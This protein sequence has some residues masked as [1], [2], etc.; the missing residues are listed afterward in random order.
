ME[1]F[2]GLENLPISYQKAVIC[3]GNF[4]GVHTGHRQII[5]ICIS[6][7]QKMAAKS[8]LVTFDRHPRIYFSQKS[9][10][11]ATPLLN[12]ND[13]KNNILSCT[14]LDG[15]LYLEMTE[16]LLDLE[17]ERFLKDVIVDKIKVSKVVFGYDFHFGKDRKGN[18][19][20]MQFCG[21]KYHFDV[22]QVGAL[23]KENEIVSSSLIRKYLLAG[24]LEKSK[25]LLGYDYHFS[26]T[27]VYGSGRGTGLGFPTANVDVSNKYKL[28]PATGV[29]FTKVKINNETK[30]GLCNIG[31][32]P[33]FDEQD[34][35]IEIYIYDL[36][37]KNLY[38]RHIE[39]DLL[40]RLRDEIRYETIEKLIDQMKLDK[41]MGENLMKQYN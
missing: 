7:A 19:D 2:H 12:T 14:A 17:A 28:I 36:D 29:Y 35:I 10:C 27:V 8:L 39:V 34:L 32:R 21:E 1:I 3:L 41:A 20:L 16:E 30:F 11:D 40:R 37:G 18:I 22:I 4:D 5:E 26:G 38:H 13:E 25:G 31:T 33:T 9:G 6:E 23:K 15:V 24:D